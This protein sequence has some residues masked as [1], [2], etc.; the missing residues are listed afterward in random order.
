MPLIKHWTDEKV[1]KRIASEEKASF[2]QGEI[3]K[4][5]YP[6]CRKGGQQSYLGDV[7]ETAYRNFSDKERR[8][9]SFN[10]PDGVMTKSEIHEVA[11]HHKN[12]EANPNYDGDN[13][14][15]ADDTSNFVHN[16]IYLDDEN[17]HSEKEEEKE[18]DKKEEEKDENK[19]KKKEDENVKEKNE[20]EQEEEADVSVAVDANTANQTTRDISRVSETS[21][22]AK[23]HSPKSVLAELSQAWLDWLQLCNVKH[24]F[25]E[26]DLV[27][28]PILLNIHYSAVVVNMLKGSIQYLDNRI[29]ETTDMD[30]Y[31][32]VAS[33]SDIN[34][35]RDAIV[36]KV[37][38]FKVSKKLDVEAEF[39]ELKE[40]I[41]VSNFQ[42][43]NK[44]CVETMSLQFNQVIDYVA[45]NDYNLEALIVC[46]RANGKRGVTQL[47]KTW[48]EWTKTQAMDLN[49]A[50]CVFFPLKKEDQY[51]VVVINFRNETVDQLDRTKYEDTEE[52][53]SIKKLPFQK[54]RQ[55]NYS[56]SYLLLHM[57]A[58]DGVNGLGLG[59]IKHE[60]ERLKHHHITTLLLILLNEENQMQTKLLANVVE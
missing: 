24:Q 48:E 29:Y 42:K 14:E 22:E 27:F 5:V 12:P 34:S 39:S 58:Y 46:L 13:Q 3:Q 6:V 28:I 49:E 2:G 37:S 16:A 20:K 53:E 23:D 38:K 51:F 1:R 36:D 18:E 11:H 31:K 17:E 47:Q 4:D 10:L 52:W 41:Y 43:E 45:I 9:V 33:T 59:S 7:I 35:Y 26:V 32:N 57:K 30:Y 15:D 55:D 60:F 25:M 50:G 54:V 8:L 19:E 21:Q 40:M 56:E 44:D